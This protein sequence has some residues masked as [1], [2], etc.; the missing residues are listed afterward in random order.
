MEESENEDF[1]LPIDEEVKAPQSES[2]KR[3]DAL[4]ALLGLSKI[5]PVPFSSPQKVKHIYLNNMK[6]LFNFDG[7]SWII[8]GLF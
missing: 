7:F 6:N 4:E 1:D 8:L 5:S 3:N 2:D